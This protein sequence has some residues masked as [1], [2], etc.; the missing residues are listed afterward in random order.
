[1]DEM[2]RMYITKYQGMICSLLYLTTSRPNIIFCVCLYS[3]FQACSKK[4]HVSA[5][6]HIF[7]YLYD[8]IDLGLWYPKES[9]LS[10]IIYLGADFI[11]CKVS[12][13]NN[14]G[15][16]HFLETSLVS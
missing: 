10:L 9:N 16:C 6:K 8:S 3:C 4:S 2:V 15:T 14:S 7:C 1:M 5:I 13:K 12:K 11:G